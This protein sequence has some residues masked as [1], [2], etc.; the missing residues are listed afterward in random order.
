MFDDNVV[1]HHRDKLYKKL[2][3]STT[4][5]FDI[6][7]QQRLEVLFHAILIILERNVLTIRS[8]GIPMTTL[9]QW[10]KMLHLLT[11]C[12]KLVLA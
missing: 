1:E 3:L 6:L 5:S 9:N 4:D 12:L 7:T 11:K 8:I 2:F 10:G